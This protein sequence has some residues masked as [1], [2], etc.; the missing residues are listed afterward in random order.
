MRC[1]VLLSIADMMHDTRFYVLALAFGL[2]PSVSSILTL[3]FLESGLVTDLSL[4]FIHS[5]TRARSRMYK[6]T[7]GHAASIAILNPNFPNP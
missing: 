3:A 1:N 6:C 2:A 4:L 5:T 7:H